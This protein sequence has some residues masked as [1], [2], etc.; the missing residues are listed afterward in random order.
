MPRDSRNGV[1]AAC[2]AAGLVLLLA[3][4][5]CRAR[6]DASPLPIIASVPDFS[7]IDQSGGP[8]RRADLLGKV[9]IADFIFTRCAGPCPRMSQVMAELQGRLS[10]IPGVRLVSFSVD[11][12]R[13][14]PAILTEYASRYRADHNRWVFIT[15]GREEIYD[16]AIDGFKLQ[17]ESETDTTPILHSTHLLL[18]DRAGQIRGAFDGEDPATLPKLEAAV[19]RL[20]AERGP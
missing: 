7:L 19:R 11:P 4:V 6:S 15:G 18:V 8:I 1:P 3:S 13:D 16:L 12:E 9:W 14:T 5:G 10:S 17:V 2:L 20:A